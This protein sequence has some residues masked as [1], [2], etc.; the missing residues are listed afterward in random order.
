MPERTAIVTGAA[1]GIGEAVVRTLAERG[2]HV[3]GVDRDADRLAEV[4]AKLAAEGLSVHA[5]PADI[6]DSAQAQRVVAEAENAF[7]PVD[8][9]VN[10]AGVLRLGGALDLTDED[11][12]GTF[13]VNTAG[14]FYM[15]RAAVTRM[16]ARGR[17]AVVT[18]ASNAASTPRMNMTAYASSK[19]AAAMFTKCLGLEVA[20]RGIRCNLVAPGSTETPML[21]SMWADETG[22]QATLRGSLE[23]YR[24]GIP[25]A[26]LA[27]P[28]DVAAAVAFLLSDQAGHITMHELTVDGGATLG[29]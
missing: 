5:L 27:S 19:A 3:V 2:G 25:L 23:A 4:M 11:W 8:E 26:K 21:T 6:T 24:L 18:I 1:G 9:L 12:A 16:A 20:G 17:G 7:G 13:A 10:G 14:V 22:P 29:A 28:A 15:S